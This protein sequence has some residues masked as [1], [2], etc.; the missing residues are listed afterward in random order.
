MIIAL[1]LAF[2]AAAQWAYPHPLRI[3][4]V[5]GAAAVIYQIAVLLQLAKE[6]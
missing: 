2:T 4:F 6:N 1:Y 5:I 3:A